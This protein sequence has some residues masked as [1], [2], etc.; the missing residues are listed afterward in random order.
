MKNIKKE[1]IERIFADTKEKH[2]MRY[3]KYRDLEKLG[4]YD[5]CFRRSEPEK[6]SHLAVGAYVFI[7]FIIQK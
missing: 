6:I 2:G 1:T 3:T 7:S 4:A 5:A